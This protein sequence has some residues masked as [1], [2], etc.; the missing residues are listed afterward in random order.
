MPITSRTKNLKARPNIDSNRQLGNYSVGN[1][2][3][4][5]QLTSERSLLNCVLHFVNS[6]YSVRIALRDEGENCLVHTMCCHSIINS[7]AL[8]L[9]MC[10]AIQRGYYS[11]K[12]NIKHVSPCLFKTK[13][14]AIFIVQKEEHPRTM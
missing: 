6:C 2:H 8:R 14:L 4:L 1:E 7:S 12:P 3:I 9:Y 10:V 11:S 13:N 5:V